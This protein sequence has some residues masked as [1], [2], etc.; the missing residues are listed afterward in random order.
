MTSVIWRA[1]RCFVLK[2]QASSVGI[3]VQDRFLQERM[4]SLGNAELFRTSATLGPLDG[5]GDDD[6]LT[7]ATLMTLRM[8][9]ER[10]E[11]LSGQINELNQRLHRLVER[12]VPQLL[13]PVAIGPDGAVTLLVIM[14][15]NSERLNME[16]SFAT[17]RAVGP[18]WN[19]S[20]LLLVPS[21]PGRVHGGGVRA[22]RGTAVS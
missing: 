21:W 5:G 3:V 16:A 13:A 14:G 2:D 22:Q 17:L 12:H 8:L 7:Q 15:H 4:F 19:P 6:G 11:Q 1:H 10:I 9:A 20:P 18:S